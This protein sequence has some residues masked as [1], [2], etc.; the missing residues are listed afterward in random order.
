MICE[1]FCTNCKTYFR[2]DRKCGFGLAT[3]LQT[4]I[5]ECKS[6][7]LESQMSYL[8]LHVLMYYKRLL[9]LIKKTG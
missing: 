8:G 7:S 6:R 4:F 3:K 5:C 1:G 9:Y 2:E